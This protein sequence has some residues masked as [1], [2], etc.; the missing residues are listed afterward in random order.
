[1]RPGRTRILDADTGAAPVNNRA[2]HIR[3]AACREALL[4][5]IE[6]N[7]PLLLPTHSRATAGSALPHGGDNE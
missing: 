7:L 6:S 2:H 3:K 4:Q 1:M 5:G